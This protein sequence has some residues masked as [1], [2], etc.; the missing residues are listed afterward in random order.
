M[1]HIVIAQPLAISNALL[2]TLT[3]DLQKDGFTI[4][5]YDSLPKGQ[6]ELGDRLADADLA[7]IA[8]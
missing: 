6:D 1:K 8:N 5:A 4:T 3:T 7:V 2:D